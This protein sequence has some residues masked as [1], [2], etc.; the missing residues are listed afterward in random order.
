MTFSCK[1]C[2]KT[3]TTKFNL[4]EHI[5]KVP[6]CPP[7]ISD[8]SKQELL[9]SLVVK[10]AYK[11]NFCEKTFNY[12]SNQSRHEINDCKAKQELELKKHHEIVTGSHS[13]SISGSNNT[14]TNNNIVVNNIIINPIGKEDISYIRDSRTFEKFIIDCVKNKNNGIV[15]Y[16]VDKHLNTEHPEN[17]NIRPGS[18]DKFLK[19]YDTNRKWKIINRDEILDKIYTIIGVEFQSYV[20]TIMESTEDEKP[21]IKKLWLDN[22]MKTVGDALDWDLDNEQYTYEGDLLS[23]KQKEQKKKE[24]FNLTTEYIQEFE[25]TKM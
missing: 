4:I 7:T 23:E 24:L 19:Y 20:E 25:N 13:V 8:L 16:F 17:N 9:D 1:R 2:D 11:C 5:K 18:K 3:Y 15:N 14:V 22:L 12:R 21:K 6:Q 10:K